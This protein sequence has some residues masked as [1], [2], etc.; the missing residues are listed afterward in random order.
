VQVAAKQIVFVDCW[1][2]VAPCSEHANSL[3][4]QLF[5]VLVKPKPHRPDGYSPPPAPEAQQTMITQT[6]VN[7]KKKPLFISNTL[8]DPFD[9]F[10]RN[11]IE[12]S[13]PDTPPIV[14]RLK[15]RGRA[16]RTVGGLGRRKDGFRIA[17]AIKRKSTRG[18]SSADIGPPRSGPAHQL[19]EPAVPPCP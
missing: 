16:W 18:E 8:S 6:P 11:M 14:Q 1:Y 3:T 5:N 4:L 12:R 10:P 13:L 19:Q 2:R 17:G 9:P 15:I 7:G